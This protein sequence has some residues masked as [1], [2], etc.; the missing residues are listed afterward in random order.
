MLLAQ[1]RIIGKTHSQCQSLQNI[2]YGN[3]RAFYARLAAP[4]IGINSEV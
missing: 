1:Q 4:N 3:P 2:L